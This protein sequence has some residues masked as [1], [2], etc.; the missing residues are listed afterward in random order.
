VAL[1][2]G[3]D[4]KF[5]SHYRPWFGDEMRDS[6]TW[7]YRLLGQQLRPIGVGHNTHEIVD[8]SVRRRQLRIESAYRPT[9][10]PPVA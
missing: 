3:V 2:L 5:L 8:E 10:V 7:F 1:G 4:E 6:M 9:N